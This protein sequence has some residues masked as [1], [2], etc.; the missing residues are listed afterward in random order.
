MDRVLARRLWCPALNSVDTADSTTRL[1]D[2]YS[3]PI[4]DTHSCLWITQAS[5]SR[6]VLLFHVSVLFIRVSGSPSR[7]NCEPP[8]NPSKCPSVRVIS[9]IRSTLVE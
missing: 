3:G 8:P 1:F 7:E 9:A 6:R 4:S 5:L 2:V